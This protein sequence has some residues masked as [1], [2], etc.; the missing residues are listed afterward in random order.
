MLL[1][2]SSRFDS[3]KDGVCSPLQ[4]PTSK[5]GYCVIVFVFL[6]FGGTVLPGFL[7]H[8][9]DMSVSIECF[10]QALFRLPNW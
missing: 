6:S 10:I 2:L 7:A 8:F 9:T 5:R 4:A 3:N 1:Q